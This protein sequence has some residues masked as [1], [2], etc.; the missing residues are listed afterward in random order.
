MPTHTLAM[1]SRPIRAWTGV[2]DHEGMD[3]GSSEWVVEA[4]GRAKKLA[5]LLE[6]GE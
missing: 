4:W 3:T 2:S 1:A 6:L 5:L